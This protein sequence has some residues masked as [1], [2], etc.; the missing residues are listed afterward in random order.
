MPKTGTTP[1]RAKARAARKPA[2]DFNISAEYARLVQPFLH[3]GDAYPHLTGFSV[4]AHPKGGA[5]IIGT[6][7]VMLA[8]FHD[9]SG[10]CRKPGIVAI[11]RDME[12][13]LTPERD[14]SEHRLVARG[15][16]VTV[17]RGTLSV[18]QHDALIDGTFPKWWR[19]ID[20]RATP[21][22]PVAMPVFNLEL[23]RRFAAVAASAEGA[24]WSAVRLVP[25]GEKDAIFVLTE[26]RDFFGMLMPM[27]FNTALSQPAPWLAQATRSKRTR[28]KP[29]AKRAAA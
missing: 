24:K 5:L 29:P 3:R 22:A 12:R 27:Y 13:A 4:E 16:T 8:V 21:K 19:C 25:T 9:T 20:L 2:A 7:G 15:S 11:N 10:R 17:R 28:A 26:R 6:D 18:P 23:L 14:G 1:K